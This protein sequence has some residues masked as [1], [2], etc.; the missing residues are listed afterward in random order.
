[1][2]PQPLQEKST[3]PLKYPP[4]ANEAVSCSCQTPIVRTHNTDL[5]LVLES[6]W[7]LLRMPHR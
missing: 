2:A 5:M 6:P 3:M 4:Y 1:M 7:L